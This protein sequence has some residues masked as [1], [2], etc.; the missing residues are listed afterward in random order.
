MARD[1]QDDLPPALFVLLEGQPPVEPGDVELCIV[2]FGKDRLAADD[3]LQSAAPDV[4]GKSFVKA[5][6]LPVLGEILVEGEIENGEANLNGDSFHPQGL[7]PF[8]VE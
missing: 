5:E 3:Q 4:L 7:Q 1:G 6:V 8:Q 2:P